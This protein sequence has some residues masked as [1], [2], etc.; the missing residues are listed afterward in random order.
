MTSA[1]PN[2]ALTTAAHLLREEAGRVLE[3]WKVALC[4]GDE[5]EV[6]HMVARAHE[7]NGRTKGGG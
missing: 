6:A 1:R 4:T 2:S 3:Q 5:V 7:L